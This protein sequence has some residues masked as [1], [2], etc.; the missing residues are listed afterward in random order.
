MSGSDVPPP[1]GN[2]AV[3]SHGNLFDEPG[4]SPS[5]VPARLGQ[6]EPLA[7]AAASAGRLYR[8]AGAEGEVAEAAIPALTRPPTIDPALPLSPESVAAAALLAEQAAAAPTASPDSEAPADESLAA[9]L[10]PAPDVLE[11]PAAP[12]LVA[13]PEAAPEGA[14]Q[15]APEATADATP[16]AVDAPDASA[17]ELAALAAAPVTAEPAAVAPPIVTPP[18]VP[19]QML[20]APIAPATPWTAIPIIAPSAGTP[21][22]AEPLAAEGPEMPAPDT[23]LT[24]SRATALI[25]GVTVAAAFLDAVLRHGIG[26]ITGV[27]LVL[28]SAA[29]ALTLRRSDIWAAVVMPPLAFLAALLT[30]GQLTVSSSGSLLSRQALNIV[31]GLSLNAP[32]LI[33]AT[34]IALVIVL[35]RRRRTPLPPRANARTA[36]AQPETPAEPGEPGL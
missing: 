5:V 7:R 14:A 20:P 3:P 28:S 22:P 16:A 32:W 26:A 33:A 4:E 23:G 6:D 27:A 36:Q 17:A 35:V 29:A 10:P 24:W 19:A 34:V 1:P 8:S 2:L 9:E 18:I 25:V 15:A 11:P 12:P 13:S 30:A 21:A 31:T